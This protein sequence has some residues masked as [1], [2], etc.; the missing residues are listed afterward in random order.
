MVA[1]HA[2]PDAHQSRPQPQVRRTSRSL[3]PR[4]HEPAGRDSGGALSSPDASGFPTCPMSRK[5]T[6]SHRTSSCEP[7]TGAL[8]KMQ[9]TSIPQTNFR[10]T[11]A[12][13]NLYKASLGLP[14]NHHTSLV[15]KPSGRDE[16]SERR[17]S[18]RFEVQRSVSAPDSPRQLLQA[19]ES[20][21][22]ASQA[23]KKNFAQ[24]LRQAFTFTARVCGLGVFAFT[25]EGLVISR[26][27]VTPSRVL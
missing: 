8:L 12:F 11:Q 22:K 21:G 27:T 1:I 16:T 15:Y 24:A 23:L 7:G 14:E 3:P 2:R 9:L 6:I 10:F 18:S 20:P 19:M 26:Y 13:T 5:A 4:T 25:I 17:S